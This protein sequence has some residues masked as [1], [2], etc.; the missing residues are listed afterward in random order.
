[1]KTNRNASTKAFD[2]RQR[3]VPDA[4]G[5]CDSKRIGRPIGS[6]VET[7]R[8]DGFIDE[9]LSEANGIRS[10][11]RGKTETSAGGARSDDVTRNT[12][13]VAER[14]REKRDNNPHQR[15]LGEVE[16]K[17]QQDRRTAQRDVQEETNRSQIAAEKRRGG[18]DTEDAMAVEEEEKKEKSGERG[19]P[20]KNPYQQRRG[21]ER[22]TRLS[23]NS[24]EK[25]DRSD[26]VE[27]RNVT[28]EISRKPA[29][30]REHEL[31]DEHGRHENVENP[32]AR[33]DKTKEE[34]DKDEQADTA[35]LSKNKESGSKRTTDSVGDAEMGRS[36]VNEEGKLP[37]SDGK[38]KGA[39]TDEGNDPEETRK[40]TANPS[41][42]IEYQL[43][44][45]HFVELGWTRLPLTKIMRK[46]VRYEAR[47]AK[48]GLDWHR[49]TEYYDDGL[50]LF[51]RFHPD[52]S[53]ELFY[54]NGVLAIRVYRPE[55][56]KCN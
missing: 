42:P 36:V 23:D 6:S 4:S 21:E 50:T 52:G 31:E 2:K 27:K 49:G 25:I 47:P 11:R 7:N 26:R 51:S 3:N 44:N 8:R 56:R 29:K 54:P 35:F 17:N 48:P 16:D 12:D 45:A 14:I 32:V 41:N 55:N 53:G 22:E 10:L 19:N 1:M 20:G 39:S 34:R 15:E 40:R 9:D 18:R 24:A 30:R 28:I 33:R 38:R 43:S 46:I 13:T 37:A 5:E